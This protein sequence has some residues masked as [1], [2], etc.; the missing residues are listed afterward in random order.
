MTTATETLKDAVAALGLTYK[1]DFVPFSK[2]RNAKKVTK[3]RDYSLNWKVTINKGSRSITTD[4]MQG[5]AHIPGY[6][7]NTRYTTDQWEALKYAC[8]NGKALRNPGSVIPTGKAIPAPELHD[9]MHSL[10]LDAS[11]LDAGSF[12]EWAG[13][14]GYE[15]DSRSAEKIYHQCMEIALRLRA[16]IGDA[17]IEALRAA[18]QDY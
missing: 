2:S 11:A 17:G 12:E 5:I 4:Y 18:G 1:A 6:A 16:M 15:T 10:V 13:D 7:Q 3:P 14:F 8:E 9:V